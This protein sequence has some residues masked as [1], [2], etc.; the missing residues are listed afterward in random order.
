LQQCEA[1]VQRCQSLLNSAAVLAISPAAMLALVDL[2]RYKDY[3]EKMIDLTRRRLLQDEVIPAGE[4]IYSIF[5]PH[6]E[7]ITKGKMNKKV[8]LGHLLL[9]TTD[10]YC[11]IV[12][13]KVMEGEKDPSQIPPL[14]QRIKQKFKDRKIYSHS[15][16]K[17]FYSKVNHDALVESGVQEVI[18]PKKG[19]LNKEEKEREGS[20]QFK[21]LRYAHSAIE[22]N[23][24]MLEHH[25]LNR[26]ADKGLRG[27][28]R[29]VGLSVLA[30]NLHILGNCLIEQEKQKEEKR[31]KRQAGRHRLAA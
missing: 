16:D 12:D 6:T 23:I 14:V 26:C 25:G 28:K 5:E 21:Q 13:Y 22:S 8:E 1:L 9:I 3:A 27:Y 4:K 10:Q 20:K 2:R 24:N 19:K 7:W 11:F 30:Y 31:L 15:F 29:Y 17:G 18:M